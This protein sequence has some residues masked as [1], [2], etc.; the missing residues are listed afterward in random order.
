MAG[1][2]Q[3]RASH[4]R[5]QQAREAATQERIT[6]AAIGVL[7]AVAI[8]AAAG[9]VWGAILPARAH[10]ITVG[11]AKFDVRAVERR[12]EFLAA[13]NSQS[14][15]DPITAAVKMIRRDETLLQVGASEAGE[16]SADDMTKAIRKRLGVPDADPVED[17][18]KAYETFLKGTN[19][20][21]PT[22]ERMV[23]AQVISDRLAKN[24][25]S[26]IGDAGPQFHLMSAASRDQ[27][28]LKQFRE[29]VTGGADFVAKAVEMGLTANP[30]AADFGWS[31]PPE[32]GFLKDVARLQDLQAGQTTEVIAREGNLQYVVYRMAER[33]EKRAYT[34]IHKSTL[35]ERK[36][37]E[38]IT[39]QGDK[40]QIVEDLSTGERKWILKRVTAAAQKLAE[41][42]AAAAKARITPRIT[43]LPGGN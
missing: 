7:V 6:L 31:L 25:E 38:W 32:T 17:Y 14:Q 29:A 22:F 15:D 36:V 5:E 28:K 37:E 2:G 21:K 13:G 26:Q 11:N 43:I 34:D 40:L 20:D 39:Q 19:V 27:G 18:A 16:I 8:I 10:V 24:F 41:Q 1:T 23:R 30:Q 12:A 4:R 35:G 3:S 9:V 33:D 42:R